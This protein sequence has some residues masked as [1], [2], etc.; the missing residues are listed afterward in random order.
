ME[1]KIVSRADCD[2]VIAKCI[3]SD[4]FEV[5]NFKVK[6]FEDKER[7]YYKPE[8]VL[9]VSAKVAKT[10]NIARFRFFLKKL[11]KLELEWVA[12]S[13]RELFFYEFFLPMLRQALDGY[14]TDFVAQYLHG[15][16]GRMMILEDMS[17][18]FFTLAKKANPHMLDRFHLSLALKAIAKLHA[19]S[20]RLEGTQQDTAKVFDPN[21]LLP[22]ES[23]WVS[24]TAGALQS[25]LKGLEALLKEFQLKANLADLLQ[26]TFDIMRPQTKYRN[27][28]GHGD[29]HTKNLLFKYDKAKMPTDCVLLNFG[30][31]RYFMPGYDVLT[32]IFRSTTRLFRQHYFTYLIE[33]YHDC[34]HNELL[35]QV[36]FVSVFFTD[37][38]N[39]RVLNR[40]DCT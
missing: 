31:C 26:L 25:S 38:V 23:Y 9:E 3:N 1:E 30:F 28:V 17:L 19:G 2:V 14:E 20:L 37:Y 5:V 35:R 13:K 10:K 40:K 8:C 18:K 29:L 24:S 39:Q 27:V 11:A 12:A 33:Y 4:K 6:P 15:E 34:L 16:I 22:Q 7:E 32:L 21:H 36:S